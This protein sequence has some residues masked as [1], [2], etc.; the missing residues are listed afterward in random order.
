MVRVLVLAA[1]LGG[2]CNSL[3]GIDDIH[4]GGAAIDGAPGGPDSRFDGAPDAPLAPARAFV[5]ASDYSAPGLATTIDGRTGMVHKDVL[6]GVISS[7]PIVRRYGDEIFVVNRSTSQIVVVSASTLAMTKTYTLPANSNPQDVAAAGT[8]LYVA[9]LASTGAIV[10]DRTNDMQKTIAFPT[11]VDPDGHPDCVSIYY[12]GSRIYLACDTLDASFKPRGVG[13]LGVI[14]PFNDSYVGTI[15]FP[16]ANPLGYLESTTPATPTTGTLTIGLVPSFT[17]YTQGCLA[18]VHLT[19]PETIDCMVSNTAMGGYANRAMTDP[20]GKTTWI[21]STIYDSTTF[22][23][24]GRLV[25]F[26]LAMMKLG[27]PVSEPGWPVA[28][29]GVCTD[30][31]VVATENGPAEKGARAYVNGTAGALIDL[32]KPPVFGGGL[33]CY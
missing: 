22:S 6:P 5:V 7:D 11:T 16:Y 30:D 23:A 13:K 28:D 18:A 2:G 19:S 10:I 12:T 17:D 15:D 14:D 20:D 1:V 29:L 9:A 26:D 33:V 4:P 21:A 8:K 27:T 31:V 25:G 3:L 24:Y 32:G